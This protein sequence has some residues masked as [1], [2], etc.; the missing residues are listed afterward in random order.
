MHKLI[1][2]LIQ[3]IGI[4]ILLLWNWPGI[5]DYKIFSDN[6][7]YLLALLVFIIAFRNQIFA[8][9]RLIIRKGKRFIFFNFHK[10]VSFL[11]NI[12]L[13]PPYNEYIVFIK[14]KSDRANALKFAIPQLFNF[15]IINELSFFAQP[16]NTGK[17]LSEYSS[18]NEHWR[19]GIHFSE[20][21]DVKEIASYNKPLIH[22]TKENG[23]SVLKIDKYNHDLS[24]ERKDLGEIAKYDNQSMIGI[25]CIYESGR[26]LVRFSLGNTIIYEE[27]MDSKYKFIK[28]CVWTDYDDKPFYYDETKKEFWY[29]YKPI[30]F[31]TSYR[32]EK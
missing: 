29:Q 13:F 12:N 17:N 18:I 1:V 30:L 7:L 16:D 2:N 31:K 23:D 27:L 6:R 8:I 5:E 20:D 24:K 9:Y 4:C 25:R 11:L 3:A 28:F 32:I 14:P 10:I 21:S 26:I 15:G 19:I 22:L